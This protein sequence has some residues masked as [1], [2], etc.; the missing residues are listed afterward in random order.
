MEYAW[1]QVPV[2]MF[3][4]GIVDM[5]IDTSSIHSE[6]STGLQQWTHTSAI[7]NAEIV[8]VERDLPVRGDDFTAILEHLDG[9][10]KP[11][12]DAARANQPAES[13]QTSAASQ[14]MPQRVDGLTP[15][16]IAA[17]DSFLAMRDQVPT[18]SINSQ[19]LLQC[20]I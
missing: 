7:D 3:S 5:Q 4:R 17:R 18:L 20:R 11:L 2:S 10:F 16:D 13:S 15:E 12:L 9:L 8:A 19:V 14:Q 6:P 1:G